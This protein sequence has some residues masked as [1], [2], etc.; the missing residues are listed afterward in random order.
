MKNLIKIVNV[1][2]SYPR[3][4]GASDF[5]ALRTRLLKRLNFAKDIEQDYCL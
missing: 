1:P 4:R 5:V 3:N 2:I